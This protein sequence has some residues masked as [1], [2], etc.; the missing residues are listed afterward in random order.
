[1]H[2]QL[3]HAKTTK[4]KCKKMMKKQSIW[5]G[6]ETVR[7]QP[8]KQ[9]TKHTLH[10]CKIH[11][12]C[13]CVLA[14]V[15]VCDCVSATLVL[16]ST[17]ILAKFSMQRKTDSRDMSI[18]HTSHNCVTTTTTTKGHP[19]SYE[20]SRFCN[21]RTILDL[22]HRLKCAFFPNNICILH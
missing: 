10:P 17:V 22:D 21:A 16:R 19:L 20:P 13:K 5:I 14:R 1:M 6:N 15:C 2:H 9:H 4:S 18:A 11:T 3:Q 8:R 12:W 7:T